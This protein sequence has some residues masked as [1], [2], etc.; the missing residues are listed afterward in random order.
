MS[1]IVPVDGEI[2]L[3]SFLKWARATSTGGQSKHYILSGLVLV[4]GKVETRR[5][6]MLQD[7][8]LVNF[9]GTEYIVKINQLE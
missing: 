4:N 6:R 1:N 5:G 9:D 7:R 8:D 2:R 3:D